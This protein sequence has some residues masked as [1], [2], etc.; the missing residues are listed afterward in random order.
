MGSS[1][2]GDICQKS[3]SDAEPPTEECSAQTGTDGDAAKATA[4]CTEAAQ[5]CSI[6]RQ[7]GQ[8]CCGGAKQILRRGGPYRQPETDRSPELEAPRT[9][10]S[11][12]QTE[13]A[14]SLSM[15]AINQEPADDESQKDKVQVG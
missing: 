4:S 7:P 14:S 1:C 9:Q 6:K 12:T 11:R 13:R 8:C 2:S 10:K 15:L 5:R 3:A